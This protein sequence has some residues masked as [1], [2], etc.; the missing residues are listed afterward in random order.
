MDQELILLGAKYAE[1]IGRNTIS[2]I[3][4]KVQTAKANRNKDEQIL[5]YEDIINSLIEDKLELQRIT[6]EYK[7]L[8]ERVTISDQDI[9]YLHN[10]LRQFLGILFRLSPEQKENEEYLTFL[11]D[12]VN[13]DTLKTLQLIGFSYKDAIGK[14]LTELCASK[15]AELGAKSSHKGKSN[16]GG[17]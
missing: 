9:E 11:I 4:D 10:T 7:E 1:I 15:I 6:Q 3:R 8:Y 2:Y 12:L 14:P 13:K 5:V 16:R 17:R